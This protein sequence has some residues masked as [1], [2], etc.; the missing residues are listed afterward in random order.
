[1]AGFVGSKELLQA[2]HEE[3]AWRYVRQSHI[4]EVLLGKD[5]GLFEVEGK[6]IRAA[7]VHW[8]F[9]FEN[10]CRSLPKVLFTPVRRRAHP[11]VME[12]GLKSPESKYLVLAPDKDMA[13]RIG[14]RR[15]EKTVP[16]EI[17]TRTAQGGG[18]LFFPFGRLFLCD[19]IPA[20]HISGPPVSQEATEERS[21]KESKR[22]RGVPRASDIR[23]G[24]FPLDISRD[25][26]LYRRA[27]GRKRKGWKE[28]ARRLRRGKRR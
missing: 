6:H 21:P 4:N 25:P 12:N 9:D 23:P 15:D 17:S 28:A 22:E 5:R 3:E 1:M 16:L 2:I 13:L 26:D 19:R 14:R 8:K 7:E 20:K 24:T 18:V 10:P 27:K 11:V